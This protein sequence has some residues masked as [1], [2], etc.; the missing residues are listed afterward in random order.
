MAQLR[1]LQVIQFVGRGFQIL[2]QLTAGHIEDGRL[3]RNCLTPLT[4]RKVMTQRTRTRS[5]YIFILN[6]DDLKN[7]NKNSDDSSYYILNLKQLIFIIKPQFLHL[8]KDQLSSAFCV[9]EISPQC[10]AHRR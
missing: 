6:S 9:P 3:G 8:C 1:L 4:P 2:G 5:L 10:R 7:K